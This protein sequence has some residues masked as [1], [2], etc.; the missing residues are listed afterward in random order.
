[1][2]AS[3]PGKPALDLGAMTL[4]LYDALTLLFAAFAI[5]VLSAWIVL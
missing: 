1:M 2:P 4:D 3:R 5:V